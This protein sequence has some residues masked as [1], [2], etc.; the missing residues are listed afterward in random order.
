[1]LQFDKYVND[2]SVTIRIGDDIDN[3]VPS[4]D[5]VVEKPNA[6]EESLLHQIEVHRPLGG[7]REIDGTDII[8]GAIHAAD[9][10][11]RFIK[12]KKDHR[13]EYNGSESPQH[14]SREAT[15][16]V[17]PWPPTALFDV[18]KG[19]AKL[20][21][22]THGNSTEISVTDVTM[23]PGR[24]SL[25]DNIVAKLNNKE[26]Y[27]HHRLELLHQVNVIDRNGRLLYVFI[28]TTPGERPEKNGEKRWIQKDIQGGQ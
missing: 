14:G 28:N 26:Y 24:R 4:F 16:V 3:E 12:Y 8:K 7:I 23:T 6:A 22:D 15:V 10:I 21:Y 5:I 18:Q 13:E 27:R 9:K 1:M 25:S 2:P 19:K 17:D 11:G 20:V